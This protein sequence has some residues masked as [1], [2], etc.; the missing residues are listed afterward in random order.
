MLYTVVVV[1]ERSIQANLRTSQ[2]PQT[3]PRI[4]AIN[5]WWLSYTQVPRDGH[6][7]VRD[8]V[9]GTVQ[10][11]SVTVDDQIL[12]KT[13]GYPTYH[14]AAV[15]DDHCMEISHVLRGEVYT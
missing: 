12:L 5:M 10:V 8:L 15:V 1:G 7:T 6:T 13:D 14:L 11:K 4:A 9:Y 2:F 3:H